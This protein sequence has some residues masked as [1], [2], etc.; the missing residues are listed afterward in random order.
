MEP[1]TVFVVFPS[2]DCLLFLFSFFLCVS[3]RFRTTGDTSC[4]L[5][6][7]ST[8]AVHLHDSSQFQRPKEE[9][10]KTSTGNQQNV[11]PPGVFFFLLLFFLSQVSHKFTEFMDRLQ[12]KERLVNMMSNIK[13]ERK[14]EG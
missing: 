13:S 4:C 12:R 7:F 10:V 2:R 3:W 11:M 9:T 8:T 14:L 6:L 5:G 1:N